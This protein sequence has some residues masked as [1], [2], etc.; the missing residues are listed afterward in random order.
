MDIDKLVKLAHS[1]DIKIILL[2]RGKI[3]NLLSDVDLFIMVE[4]INVEKIDFFVKKV[5]DTIDVSVFISK[6]GFDE[7]YGYGVQVLAK[8]GVRYDVNIMPENL[9][10]T[11][12]ARKIKHIIYIRRECNIFSNLENVDW[13]AEEEKL[14]HTFFIEYTKVF[15]AKSDSGIETALKYY[16]RV[17]EAFNKLKMCKGEEIPNTG[18]AYRTKIFEESLKSNIVNE[19]IYRVEYMR[20]LTE[21]Y[22]KDIITNQKMDLDLVDRVKE[23]YLTGEISYEKPSIN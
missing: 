16:L 17:Y 21:L 9:V 8:S 3:R 5:I 11:I 4:D 12:W 20:K 2:G 22:F 10:T 19:I 15:K 6:R 23:L 18:D 14:L 1:K 13:K 7:A